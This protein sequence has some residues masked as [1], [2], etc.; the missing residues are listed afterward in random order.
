MTSPASGEIVAIH[1]NLVS[2][3]P[4]KAVSTARV[5]ES[6]IEGDR[7]NA[8]EGPRKNRQ[9]LVMDRETLDSLDLKPSDI[10]ENVT[11]FGLDLST[12]EAGHRISLGDDVVL[13]ITGPCDPCARMDELRSGLRAELDGRRGKVAF[14]VEGGEIKVGDPIGALESASAD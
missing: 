5:I 3:E 7:H 4:M 13:E 8:T 14:V 9:V 2:R 10:R 12:L 11:T 1:L 6:G